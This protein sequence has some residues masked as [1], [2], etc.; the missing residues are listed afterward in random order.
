MDAETE[1][2]GRVCSCKA[3]GPWTQIVKSKQCQK[4][5]LALVVPGKSTCVEPHCALQPLIH[6]ITPKPLSFD[7]VPGK[8]LQG[9]META[10]CSLH[11][12]SLRAFSSTCGTQVVL[13]LAA[14]TWTHCYIARGSCSETRMGRDKQPCRKPF[15]L[16]L[17]LKSRPNW[18]LS[19]EGETA[20]KIWPMPLLYFHVLILP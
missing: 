20:S 2:D 16:P 7:G 11:V 13:S 17:I 9:R 18:S 12:S 14:S 3:Q 4:S 8:Y 10:S 5:K 1:Y 15:D 6:L 19:P